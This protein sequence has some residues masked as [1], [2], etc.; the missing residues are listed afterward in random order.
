MN[1]KTNMLEQI[2]NVL[3]WIQILEIDE[4]SDWSRCALLIKRSDHQ[5]KEMQRLNFDGSSEP[6]RTRM[7][8]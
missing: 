8:S 5:S 4:R 2:L 3:I 7:K 6:I 1:M